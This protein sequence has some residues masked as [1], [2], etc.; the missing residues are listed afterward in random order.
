[1]SHTPFELH[2]RLEAIAAG[3]YR[4]LNALQ[5][6]RHTYYSGAAFHLHNSTRIWTG[7]EGLLPAIAA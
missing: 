2:V 3:F 7:A 4:R 6:R 5:G 1:M